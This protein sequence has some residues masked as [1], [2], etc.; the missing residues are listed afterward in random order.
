MSTIIQPPPFF[1]EQNNSIGGKL[2]VYSDP[3]EKVLAATYLLFD[4]EGMI[5][6]IWHADPPTI[7]Q[8]LEGAFRKN[9]TYY[10]CMFQPEGQER[11]EI[12]GLTWAYDVTR[13]GK[14]TIAT[15][16]MAFLRAYQHRG[17]PREFANLAIDMG[18]EAGLDVMYGYT[19]LPNVPALRFISQCGFHAIGDLP[20][21]TTFKGEAC[22]VRISVLTKEMWARP[23]SGHQE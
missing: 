8:F 12:A 2:H 19:P 20:L 16:G 5:E 13:L 14:A 11:A 23:E 3:G 18:F 10:V 22:G 21:Y 4:R 6:T 15:V 9:L 17:I 7:S 1:S